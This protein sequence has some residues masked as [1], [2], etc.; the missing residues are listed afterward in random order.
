MKKTLLILAFLLPLTLFG[1]TGGNTGNTNQQNNNQQNNNQNSSPNN[2]IYQNPYGTNPYQNPYLDPN[3]QNTNFFNKDNDQQ[4]NNQQ[5]P[6]PQN[7]LQNGKSDQ[8]NENV[9]PDQFKDLN[10]LKQTKTQEEELLELYKNDPDYIKYLGSKDKKQEVGKATNDEADKDVGIGKKVVYGA[11]FFTNNVF[12]LSDKN[13]TTPPSDYRLGPGDELIVS[14][15]GSAEL[16]Q[17]YV[18]GKDGSIFPR[19]IGKIYL[20]GMTFDAAS[21]IIENKFRKIVPQNTN[22]D[23][24]M[25]KS[26]TIRVT[27]LGE[28]AKQGTY[29]ISA[30]NTALN[31]LYR[32]GGLSSI[33]NLRKIEIKRDGRTVEIIDL[34]KY[35]QKD[36]YAD[37]VYLEDNDY[38]YVDV[39]DKIVNAEG[40]FKRPMYYQL[41]GDEGL[42]EL[43]DYAGGPLSNARNSLIHIKTISN[44][45]EKYIDIPGREYFDSYKND[46]YNDLILKDGDVVSL[47]PINPGLK[48]VVRISGSV[49]YPDEYEV[50]NG[51]KLNDILNRA[52]GIA[53]TAYLPRAYV[54]RGSNSLESDAIKIDLRDL[55]NNPSQ[56]IEIFA[57]DKIT[58][59]S[60]KD[61]EQNYTI[62]ILGNVRNPTQIQYVKN[63]KLKDALLLAG[64]LTLDAENGRIEISNI[65]DSVDKY[66][67]ESKG[68]NIRI[69]SINSNL[70]I[71]Q[72]SENLILQPLDRIYVRKKIEFVT[73]ETIQILGEIN[74][75]GEYP[76]IQKNERISSLIKRSGGLKKSAYSE[77]AKLIR[78][79]IGQ[80][81]I[82]LPLILS[83]N[84]SKHDLIL[85]DGDI[86]IIPT[87][88]DI[89][90]VRGEIQSPINMKFDKNNK[91][92]DYYI[93]SAGGYGENPWKKRINVKYQNGKIKAT[94]NFLFFR[95][96]PK[97]TEGSIVTVPKKPV[98]E[99]QTKFSEIFTYTLS[100]ITTL[101]TLLVLSKSLK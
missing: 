39:Y 3:Q 11:N 69:V 32:A 45:A 5:N 57:G 81:I 76:L 9:P 15:W 92:V 101:A 71:D 30:F 85:K 96:Y 52:G 62:Q 37:E 28:V 8:K 58:I 97:V 46:I 73:Q 6:D 29:T 64:G 89:V 40:M 59:L 77:G 56:N 84:G 83:K 18:I 7:K 74:Y 67:I 80:I 61:F 55:E 25:G 95:K 63:L 24:Q 70:E 31:A 23:V 21:R 2:S 60:T 68:N 100:A 1:Q 78:Q 54:L 65:V 44:E 86:I 48:N 47:K 14:L 82:D 38:I 88:N 36:K 4:N 72:V 19:L 94:K 90:S 43:I 93:A 79:N 33:G 66:S 27:I 99:R 22:V 87:Q 75:A 26:R 53:T 41:T 35:L 49:N 17:P 42:R 51:E 13:P 91:T 20:Q 34:Y 10:G 50:R 16:Q 12:D 98:K